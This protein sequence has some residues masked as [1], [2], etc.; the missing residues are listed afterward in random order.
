MDEKINLLYNNGFS[1]IIEINLEPKEKGD[2]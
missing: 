2:L 1:A